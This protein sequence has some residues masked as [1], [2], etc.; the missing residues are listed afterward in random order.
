MLAVSRVLAQGCVVDQSWTPD[1]LADQAD[2]VAPDA[3]AVHELV[4]DLDRAGPDPD[5]RLAGLVIACALRGR[6][7]EAFAGVTPRPVAR[8]HGQNERPVVVY[9][10]AKCR[11]PI[12]CPLDYVPTRA[13]IDSARLTY[14]RWWGA[15][16]WLRTYLP[17]V[18]QHHEIT[19]FSA[20]R[21]PWEV[22]P[23]TSGLT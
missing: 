3:L 21:V 23:E 10:D 7:P 12:Y 13:D 5:G 1:P 11:K 22:S 19:G 6:R 8:R 17:D 18:L 16:D 2:H 15:L 4:T 20:P 9:A 14:T